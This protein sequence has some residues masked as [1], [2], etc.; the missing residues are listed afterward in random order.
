MVCRK[1]VYRALADNLIEAYEKLRS[2][3]ESAELKLSTAAELPI[4]DEPFAGEEESNVTDNTEPFEDI[5]STAAPLNP[6][7]PRKPPAV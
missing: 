1:P 5:E 7:T 6:E 4:R 3:T 2:Q